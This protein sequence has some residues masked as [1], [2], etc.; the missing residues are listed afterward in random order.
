MADV[1]DALVSATYGTRLQ[2]R[3]ADGRT[4]TARIKGRK[5][6]PVC[7]DRVLA[8]PLKNESDWKITE[9]LPRQNELTRP[10]LRGKIDIL[11]ANL[12]FLLVVCAATPR[13]DWFIVDRYLCAAELMRIDAAIAYNKVDDGIVG[14]EAKLELENYRAMGYATPVCSAK[15]KRNLDELSTLL[16]NRRATIVG[17]SGVGKSSIINALT[18]G[19]QRTA[20]VSESSGEGRHTTVNSVM[21][22]LPNGG[23]VV[24]SPGVRDY[25]PSIANPADVE[26]GFREIH[27]LG[28]LCRFNNC[29]HRKE[30][31]CA[32]TKAVEDGSVSTR[33]YESYKRMLLLTE[34][35]DR[36]RF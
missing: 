24:D 18:S 9:I 11:A 34:Q 31:H 12:D 27:Q 6:K 13:T 15:A 35:Q 16:A 30:P 36:G 1:Q 5:L 4:V 29:R 26:Y 25:A 14:E 21:L 32:V 20:A 3:F 28:E 2:L 8:E 10:N 23:Y 22:M 19:D 7:G 17:Q 33:R